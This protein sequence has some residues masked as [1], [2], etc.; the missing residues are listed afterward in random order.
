MNL[1]PITIPLAVL[2]VFSLVTP[3]ARIYHSPI[4]FVLALFGTLSYFSSVWAFQAFRDKGDSMI[5]V[6]DTKRVSMNVGKISET[7]QTEDSKQPALTTQLYGGYR[8]GPLYFP[9]GNVAVLPTGAI[10]QFGDKTWI[11]YAPTIRLTDSRTLKGIYAAAANQA[12]ASEITTFRGTRKA[13]HEE[14]LIGLFNPLIEPVTTEM[15]SEMSR[16]IAARS[17]NV[18]L[19]ERALIG[20]RANME[21]LQKMIKAHIRQSP[22]DSLKRFVLGAPKVT[23][24]DKP[25]HDSRDEQ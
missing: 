5:L 1:K 15:V 14:V 6:R 16:V 21:E 13:R 11:G 4:L 3:F 20:E 25:R 7:D 24:Q 9:D 10:E 18:D 23:D 8:A 22:L 17:G 2:E 12:E 19:V